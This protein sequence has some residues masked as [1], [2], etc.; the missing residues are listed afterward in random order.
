MGWHRIVPILLAVVALVAGGLAQRRRSTGPRAAEPAAPAAGTRPPK[1]RKVARRSPAP[2]LVM[3]PRPAG[4]TGPDRRDRRTL[5]RPGAALAAGF[6]DTGAA[7]S[8][9]ASGSV[10]LK[11]FGHENG[12]DATRADLLGYTFAGLHNA[13]PGEGESVAYWTL[14]NPSA[15]IGKQRVRDTTPGRCAGTAKA[16]ASRVQMR[17]DGLQVAAKGERDAPDS[18]FFQVTRTMGPFRLRVRRASPQG[19]GGRPAAEWHWFADWRTMVTWT[20]PNASPASIRRPYLDVFAPARSIVDIGEHPGRLEWAAHVPYQAGI[21]PWA[22]AVRFRNLCLDGKPVVTGALAPGSR[23]VVM[24]GVGPGA[25]DC[26]AWRPIW[27]YLGLETRV[28][29]R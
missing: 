9:T 16:S 29:C 2:C 21:Y 1:P 4:R 7:A 15:G 13:A 19:R 17:N 24:K 26:A 12:D 14:V 8:T 23:N 28:V 5:A 25:V 18:P 10:S 3:L 20:C 11:G 6:V 22:H 27:P